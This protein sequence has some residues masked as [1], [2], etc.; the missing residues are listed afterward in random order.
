MA[1]FEM[2]KMLSIPDDHEIDVVGIGEEFA[3]IC[4]RCNRARQAVEHE[5]IMEGIRNRVRVRRCDDCKYT[6]IS[7]PWL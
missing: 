2:R 7:V 6:G 3:A 1:E 5:I 4:E